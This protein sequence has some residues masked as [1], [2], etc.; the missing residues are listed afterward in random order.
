MNNKVLC[1]IL[2]F[3]IMTYAVLSADI[4]GNFFTSGSNQG[5]TNYL[6]VFP[7]GVTPS[8]LW[9]GHVDSVRFSTTSFIACSLR[10]AIYQVVSGSNKRPGNRI[11]Y[12]ENAD[13][14]SGVG[15]IWLT[16]PIT[17]ED[18]LQPNTEYC[19][20]I[21]TN[22][23]STINTYWQTSVGDTVWSTTDYTYSDWSGNPTADYFIAD[24]SAT[25]WTPNW[26]RM[27][28][29]EVHY[30][31]LIQPASDTVYGPIIEHG[32]LQGGVWVE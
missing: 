5:I 6:R 31:A 11:A 23:S 7:L 9:L 12:Q 16:E 20:M 2:V 10:I 29:F 27:V 17:N 32:V 19:L 30:T 13:Y 4:L 3:V 14:K 18:S 26:D 22:T 21:L 24:H 8:D 15:T 28:C 25:N 1:I